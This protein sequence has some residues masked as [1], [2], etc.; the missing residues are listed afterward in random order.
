MTSF[1]TGGG[2][3]GF[4]KLSG[5]LVGNLGLCGGLIN[6]WLFAAPSDGLPDCGEFEF[7][8]GD[9]CGLAWANLDQTSSLPREG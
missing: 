5:L 3:L 1:G 8:T 4:S 7:D 9:S 6:C 2:I